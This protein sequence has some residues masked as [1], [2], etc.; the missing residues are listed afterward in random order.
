MVLFVRDRR[1]LIGAALAAVL[2]G[3]ATTYREDLRSLQSDPMAAADIS[4]ATLVDTSEHDA[5]LD[6]LMGKQQ[7]AEVL[8]T[9]AMQSGVDPASL[10]DQAVAKAEA[11]GWDI[12]DAGSEVVRGTKQLDSGT[13]SIGIY[14]VGEAGAQQLV[15]RLEHDFNHPTG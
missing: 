14:F 13:A 15:V 12:A 5:Q 2:A 8:L 11:A 4:G 3:C 10:K 9:Y 7:A 6:G 1:L